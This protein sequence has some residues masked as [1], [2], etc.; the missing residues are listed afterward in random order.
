MKWNFPSLALASGLALTLPHAA[1]AQSNAVVT[2]DV[3]QGQCGYS[4]SLA[5]LIEQNHVFVECDRMEIRR[6]QGEAEVKFAFPAR[7]R[8]VEF[9]GG[10][11]GAGV[12]QI[13]AIRLRSQPDWKES[14]GQCEFVASG[15]ETSQVKCIARDGARFFV[16]NF[17][18]DR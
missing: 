10:F 5:P 11:D 8:S 6:G 1:S 3:T 4:D 7:L 17:V 15:S 16:V 13:S 9:R 14:E 12:F 2:V 18:P